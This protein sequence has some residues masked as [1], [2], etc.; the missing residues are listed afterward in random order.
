MTPILLEYIWLDATEN[1]RSKKRVLYNSPDSVDNINYKDLI[2][3]LPKWSYDGSSTDQATG[4]KSDI[5]L[6]PV[7]IFIDP[8]NRHPK[9]LS[10][11]VLCNNVDMSGNPAIGNFR[12]TLVDS[13]NKQRGEEPLFGI[14]QEYFLLEPDDRYDT[15]NGYQWE[16]HDYTEDSVTQGPYYCSVGYG[17][18]L[19]RNIV[20]RH[21]YYCLDA[22]ITICGYN[23]EVAPSQWEFQVGPLDPVECSDQL[24]VARY[25][26]E[27]VAEEC[28]A[29][30]SYYPK[31]FD[32]LN[33]S[34]GHVNYSTYNSRARGGIEY[35]EKY[36]SL[37]GETHEKTMEYYGEDNKYRLTGIHET[38]SYNTFSW[39]Y[40]DRGK[41]IRIPLGVVN[42]GFGYLED[43]RPAAN[44]NPYRV[45]WAIMEATLY[46]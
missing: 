27:R 16:R 46:R 10:Y 9:Y 23:A 26:L 31:L 41:S 1:I 37:L 35:L 22:G 32:G 7:N 3:K 2:S 14:E 5:L 18:A 25:I 11:L 45:T 40:S 4:T 19:G 39:G 24:I 20:D 29:I 6:E 21:L 34:G 13:Y 44:L 30:V 33:G 8:F 42:D 38:S 28:G 43:R 17:K 12:Q 36:C 15:S